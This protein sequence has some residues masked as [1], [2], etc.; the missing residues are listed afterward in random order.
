MIFLNNLKTLTEIKS[1]GINSEYTHLDYKE[2]FRFE[3]P[4]EKLDL[5]KNIVAFANA[6]GGIIVFGVKNENFEW[7]GLDNRSSKL[8]D[9]QIHNYLS[10]YIDKN[11][12]FEIASYNLGD[13]T[14]YLL[15]IDKVDGPAIAFNKDGEY[16]KHL[17]NGSSKKAYAFKAGDIYA[18]I[19]AAC[20]R[21]NDDKT[22]ETIRSAKNSIISNID[23]VPLPYKTYIERDKELKSIIDA[24]N[25]SNIR[26]VQINGLGGIGKTSFIRNFCEQIISGTVD[27]AFKPQFLIWITG[28]L[29]RFEPTG[30]IEILRTYEITYDEFLSKIAEVLKIDNSVDP[31]VLQKDIYD[32]F[33]RYRVLLIVDNTETINDPKIID[34]LKNIPFETRVIFTTRQDMTTV[35]TKITLN[36]FDNDQFSSFV[37]NLLLEFIPL[38]ADG[39]YKKIEPHLYRIQDLTKGSPL[40]ATMIVYKY[41]NNASITYLL[42]GLEKCKK[43]GDYYDKLMEFCFSETFKSLTPVEKSILY[44][45]SLSDIK[46]ESFTSSDLNFI[47]SEDMDILEASLS[48]LTTVSFCNVKN[49]GYACQPL[50]K[51]FAEKA[52]I[53][54]YIGEENAKKYSESYSNWA[55][56]KK[57]FNNYEESMFL[58]T[59]AFDQKRKLAVL[60]VRELKDIYEQNQDF[61]GAIDTFNSLIKTNRE[62]GYLYFEKARF[63][64]M[65]SSNV[66]N[67]SINDCFMK[68]ISYD[69]NNDFYLGEYAFFLSKKKENEIAIKFFKKALSLNPDSSNLN[70]GI[71][72]AYINF[73]YNKPEFFESSEL[74]LGHLN[75]GYDN[76]SYRTARF[77]NCRTAH[78]QAKYLM[79]LGRLDEALEVCNKGLSFLNDDS[80]L[81]ALQG[82]IKQKINPEAVTQTKIRNIK[83]GIF[84]SI[85]DEDAKELINLF[86]DD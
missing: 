73:Y 21:V 79:N 39:A 9:N 31:K 70:F 65:N 7:V 85:S 6:D 29:N 52:N 23:K 22:F 55:K 38:K 54:K 1:K 50:V 13:E 67:E 72:V 42:N 44:I 17:L 30:N 43:S 49:D 26:N 61:D 28:K 84:A 76:A 15:T 34:F 60:K 40:L 47:T 18:R 5:I 78:C 83:T 80:R 33:K 62:Y 16:D 19:K 2:V 11:I 86:V 45:M 41:A 59:K 53:E 20:I 81:L 77:K 10:K 4:L 82:T 14:Y 51:I 36:G 69:P 71:A 58:R 56:S 3:E 32:V 46:D 35:Y 57:E 74:I 12:D 24:I 75:K 66:D 63:M 68:A 27:L 48:N 8:H 25:N 37:K 64:L